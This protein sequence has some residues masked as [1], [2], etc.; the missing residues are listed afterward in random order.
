MQDP[1]GD[2]AL[3]SG[4]WPAPGDRLEPRTWDIPLAHINT[5]P[6]GANLQLNVL[7]AGT[8][9]GTAR[10]DELNAHG[11]REVYRAEEKNA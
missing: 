6:Y 5:S 7:S 3:G 2:H 9:R 11:F 4:R 10:L 8:S 1:L